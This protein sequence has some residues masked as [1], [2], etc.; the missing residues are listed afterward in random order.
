MLKNVPQDI[1]D[2]YINQLKKLQQ[3]INS[4]EEAKKN[5]EKLQIAE[6]IRNGGTLVAL[7]RCDGL[8]RWRLISRHDN[9][10]ILLT[11]GAS[12]IKFDGQIIQSDGRLNIV[13]YGDELSLNVNN[14]RVDMLIFK[15]NDAELRFSLVHVRFDI[16]FSDEIHGYWSVWY[17]NGVLHSYYG[18][19]AV[20]NLLIA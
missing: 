8:P 3:E 17:K 16:L 5:Y 20:D 6:N 14:S 9:A 2:K 11:Q 15:Y 4:I 19:K 18:G 12:I 10:E 1:Q 13:Q 7:L